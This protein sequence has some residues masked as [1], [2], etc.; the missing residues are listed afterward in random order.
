MRQGSAKFLRSYKAALHQYL[1]KGLS[2]KTARELGATASATSLP[3]LNIASAHE[4]SLIEF[5]DGRPIANNVIKK[6]GRFFAEVILPIER[7]YRGRHNAADR[8]E[9]LRKLLDERTRTLANSKAEL[10]EEFTRRARTEKAL[11]ESERHFNESLEESARLQKQL[12]YLSHKILSTQEE[13]R[14]KIRRE[15]PD[16]LAAT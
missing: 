2:L 3:V 12:R 13:E 7:K 11:Q 14:K 16:Q 15:L 9:K 10:E 1:R 8:L 4:E 5:S 6:A